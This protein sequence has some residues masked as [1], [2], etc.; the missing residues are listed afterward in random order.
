MTQHLIAPASVAAPPRPRRTP[1]TPWRS[2]RWA[3]PLLGVAAALLSLIGAGTPSLWGDEAA[4]VMSA[5]RSIPSLLHELSAIDAVHGLYYLG[6]HFWIQLAGTSELALRLPDV[7][8]AGLAAAGVVVL[9]RRLL[10]PTTGVVAG[11]VLAILPEFTQLAVDARSYEITIAA[12]TWT[13][14]L[15]VALVTRRRTPGWMW[16]GYALAVAATVWLWVFSAMILIA[17]LALLVALRAPRDA[18]RRWAACVAAVAFAI[19]PIAVLAYAQRHQVAFLGTRD[20]AT[21]PHVLV[22]QWFGTVP[23]AVAAWALLVVAA[24]LVVRSRGARRRRGIAIGVWAFGPMAI[25]LTVNLL[26]VPIY[27]E[28]YLAFSLPAAA[29]GMA[30]GAVAIVRAVARRRRAAG[31]AVGAVLGLALV[32]SAAPAYLA[33]RGPWGEGGADFREAGQVLHAH[34]ASG[35]AVVYDRTVRASQRPRDIE[36]LYPADVAGLVDVGIDTPYAERAGIWDTTRPVAELGPELAGHP[37]VWALEV[38]GSGSPDLAQLGRLGYR[39]TAAYPVH[40]TT[41]YRLERETS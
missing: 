23:F 16:A 2:G 15:L 30:L 29:L 6:L 4:S 10:G 9:G 24:V 36:H 41:V 19:S 14:V 5:E 25:L 11:G 32:A 39:V 35:D 37:V 17:H 13:T 1:A 34:A 21:L 38:R 8:A 33:Q 27:D 7:V 18:G 12:T 20:H 31:I 26:V 3:A 40:I 22:S 28:R